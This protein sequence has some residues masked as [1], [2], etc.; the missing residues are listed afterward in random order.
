MTGRLLQE[1]AIGAANLKQPAARRETARQIG[2]Q[3]GEVLLQDLR[4]TRIVGIA[5]GMS[6]GKILLAVIAR[7][8]EAGGIG[9]SDAT[10]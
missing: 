1:V 5:I 2:G 10:V 7:G 6:A 4:C 9:T 8:I 3:S